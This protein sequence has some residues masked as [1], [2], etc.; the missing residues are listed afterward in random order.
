[1]LN[2]QELHELRHILLKQ[3]QGLALTT[4]LVETNSGFGSEKKKK[5]CQSNP[6]DLAE[7][8]SISSPCDVWMQFGRQL[9]KGRSYCCL[10]QLRL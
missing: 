7:G 8:S 2:D 9:A 1:V 10:A 3:I 6:Q 4:H 5:T